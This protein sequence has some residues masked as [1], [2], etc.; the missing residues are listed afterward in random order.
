MANIPKEQNID[1]TR[2]LL[3]FPHHADQNYWSAY[4]Y[5][6]AVH[7]QTQA[8]RRNEDKNAHSL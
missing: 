6:N 2:H 4:R 5:Q 1:H 7:T 8:I 3:G